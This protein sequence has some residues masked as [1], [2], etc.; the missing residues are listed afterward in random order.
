MIN[1]DV[2]VFT[3]PICPNCI[4]LKDDLKKNNI[5]YSEKNME[6]ENVYADLLLDSVTMTEAPIV[7]IDSI[8]YD[9]KTARKIL[10]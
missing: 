10:L 1:M 7:K 5:N 6:D 8:Y 9:L 3:L 2:T 4:V